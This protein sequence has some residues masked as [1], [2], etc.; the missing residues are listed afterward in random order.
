MEVSTGTV[1]TS[2]EGPQKIKNRIS[3]WSWVY[4]QKKQNQFSIEIPTLP[5]LL[6]HYSQ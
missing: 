3:I 6:P 4:I 1:E 5:G 2:M